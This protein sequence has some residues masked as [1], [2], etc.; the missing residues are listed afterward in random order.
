MLLSDLPD[1]RVEDVIDVPPVR[2][3]RLDK[4]AAEFVGQRLSLVWTHPPLPALLQVDF[5]AHQDHRH[6][7]SGP[8]LLKARASIIRFPLFGVLP[9]KVTLGDAPSG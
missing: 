5:V 9:H 1:E 7:V 4:L 8:N 3:R 6:M 2:R